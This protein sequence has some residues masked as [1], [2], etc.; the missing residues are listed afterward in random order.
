[1]IIKSLKI[2][3]FIIRKAVRISVISAIVYFVYLLIF[4]H[5]GAKDLLCTILAYMTIAGMIVLMMVGAAVPESEKQKE[6]SRESRDMY[7]RIA[8]ETKD[9]LDDDKLK[10]LAY[11]EQQRADNAE[12]N[13]RYA[14]ESRRKGEEQT[15]RNEEELRRIR[16]GY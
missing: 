2:M 5:A 15:R 9:K 14:E 4:D 1:M 13:R 8:Q 10:A 7:R 11:K 3:W 12:R 6:M 16:R